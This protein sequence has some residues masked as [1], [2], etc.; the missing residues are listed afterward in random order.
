M[1]DAPAPFGPHF[2]FGLYVHWPYCA[3]I[4]PYCDFNVYAAKDRDSGPLVEAIA[5]RGIEVHDL[6]DVQ[7]P[8]VFEM[9]DAGAGA[10]DLQVAGR[11]DTVQ[12]WTTGETVHVTGGR[13]A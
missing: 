1:T 13:Y 8:L 10:F 4:C 3:R 7:G 11:R 9:K 6:G 2:G 5:A 12:T